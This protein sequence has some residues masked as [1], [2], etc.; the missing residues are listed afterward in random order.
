MPRLIK[1]AEFFSHITEVGFIRESVTSP[2]TTALSAGVAKGIKV[3]PVSSIV[4]FTTGDLVIIN[5]AESMEIG[6]I[7]TA[8]TNQ[9][10][11]RSQLARAHDTGVS[12][13]RGSRVKLGDVTDDGVDLLLAE[14]D[15][16]AVTAATMRQTA[17][18]LLG[19]I[20]QGMSFAI[21]HTNSN[22][23]AAALGIPESNISGTNTELDPEILDIQ[24]DAMGTAPEFAW[25]FFGARKD[26]TLMEAQAWGVE[27]DPTA[28]GAIKHARGAPAP[29]PFN[30]RPTAGIRWLTYK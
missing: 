26:G 6:R 3:L 30:L 28:I 13:T 5:S 10:T 21:E 2:A 29:I 17:G 1:K 16:N 7:A 11:L 8:A 24:A 14:G 22:N 4:G 15:F 20:A 12:V 9:I 25:Y 23:I 19:H 27:V 18:Y